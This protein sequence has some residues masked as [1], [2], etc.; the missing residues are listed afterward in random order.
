MLLSVLGVSYAVVF[1]ASLYAQTPIF[2]IKFFSLGYDYREFIYAA[3]SIARG[4]DPYVSERIVSPPLSLFV[5]FPLASFDETT[6]VRIFFAANAAAVF[7]S[8]YAALRATGFSCFDRIAFLLI[9]LFCAPTL[10]LLERGNL[11]G[12]VLLLLTVFFLQGKRE[13]VAG[14]AL[15]LAASIKIYPIVL[16]GPLLWARKWRTA[17]AAFFVMAVPLVVLWAVWPEVCLSFVERTLARANFVR[18]DE[19]LSAANFFFEAGKHLPEQ[20][21]LWIAPIYKAALG[22]LAV[23]GVW[24]DFKR[25][26]KNRLDESTQTVLAASYLVF[27]VNAPLTV[28]LYSGVVV[29]LLLILTLRGKVPTGPLA[30]SLLAAGSALVFFPA[31][32]FDLTLQNVPVLYKLNFFPQVGGLLLLLYF[33]A[34]R[35]EK[36]GVVK[37]CEAKGAQ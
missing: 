33:V 34:L 5:N 26:R 24:A 14:V 27:A 35:V 6:A 4:V 25:N 18:F 8:I 30:L 1:L 15:G 11:D 3:K 16:F 7:G 20:A 31:R 13:G 9:T 10:M 17:A 28:Y 12:I 36:P 23:V 21:Q 29:L 37:P 19:N 2:L 32:A 22:G